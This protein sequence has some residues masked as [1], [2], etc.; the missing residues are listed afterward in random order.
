MMLDSIGSPGCR[1]ISSE[2]SAVDRYLL[3][4]RRARLRLKEWLN[5]VEL[6]ADAYIRS[7]RGRQRLFAGPSAGASG[8]YRLVRRPRPGTS[9]EVTRKEKRKRSC[10]NEL[11]KLVV[12]RSRGTRLL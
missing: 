9:K 5:V 6:R 1:E 11:S 12:D 2:Y 10:G 8:T 3:R 7:G 4:I